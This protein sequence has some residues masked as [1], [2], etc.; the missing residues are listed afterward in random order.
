[1]QSTREVDFPGCGVASYIISPMNFSYGDWDAV[2]FAAVDYI[3]NRTEFQNYT[4][5]FL[6]L[7]LILKYMNII[8]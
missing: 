5:L 8:I 7:F 1:M 4:I 2:S 3:K 6:E